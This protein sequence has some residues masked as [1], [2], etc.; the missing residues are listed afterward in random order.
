M[1]ADCKDNQKLFYKVLK[2]ISQ[3]LTA[4]NYEP[5]ENINN[6]DTVR[7]EETNSNE[8]IMEE[9]IVAINI[10][11]NGKSAR[12]DG[13]FPELIRN[14]EIQE[15]IDVWKSTRKLASKYYGTDFM[16]DT[17]LPKLQR[18]I[19]AVLQE[20]YVNKHWRDDSEV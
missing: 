15:R 12:H 7:E 19:P 18:H 9:L 14:M 4:E 17:R 2:Y 5:E 13:I 10:I 1:E 8:Y 11:K 3:L 16:Q 20:K 6:A